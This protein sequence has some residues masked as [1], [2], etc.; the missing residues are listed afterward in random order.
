LEDAGVKLLFYGNRDITLIAKSRAIYAKITA[1]ASFICKKIPFLP[2]I[3][4]GSKR[5]IPFLEARDVGISAFLHSINRGYKALNE[6]P[7]KRL[8]IFDFFSFF[9]RRAPK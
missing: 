8:Q 3:N 2:E 7:Y 4:P 5:F 1:F 9:F 6:D